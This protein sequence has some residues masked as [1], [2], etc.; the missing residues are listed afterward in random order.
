MNHLFVE[1]LFGL[2]K[3]T[4]MEKHQYLDYQIKDFIK[5][6]QHIMLTKKEN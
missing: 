5:R 4:L 6:F 2:Q 1:I 3:K